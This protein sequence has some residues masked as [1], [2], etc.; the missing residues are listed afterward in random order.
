MNQDIADD[1]IVMRILIALDCVKVV[2]DIS[3][4]AGGHHGAIANQCSCNFEECN[5]IYDRQDSDHEAEV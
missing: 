2:K 3:D 5:F 1:L 4:K